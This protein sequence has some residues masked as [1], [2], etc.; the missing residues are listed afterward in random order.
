[1]GI[2]WDIRPRRRRPAPRSPHTPPVRSAPFIAIRNFFARYP[3]RK[4]PAPPIL[5]TFSTFARSQIRPVAAAVVCMVCSLW[6]LSF[7]VRPAMVPAA[8]VRPAVRSVVVWMIPAALV[9]AAI[10]S[11][12]LP[13]LWPVGFGRSVFVKI[14]NKPKKTIYI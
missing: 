8:A 6:C 14:Y 3:F 1:M 12:A 2:N 7:A 10:L 11:A 4:F 9:P 13:D 5:Q